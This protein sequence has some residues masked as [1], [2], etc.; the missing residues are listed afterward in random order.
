MSSSVT[1]P[2]RSCQ[3]KRVVPNA[4]FCRLSSDL[5][6]GGCWTVAR[7]AAGRLDLGRSVRKCHRIETGNDR[8]GVRQ[9]RNGQVSQPAVRHDFSD[10]TAGG[11]L[12]CVS[13][14]CSCG[15]C[16]QI[17][18]HTFVPVHTLPC[19]TTTSAYRQ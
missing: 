4:L 14:S 15:R 18:T 1:P 6:A 8:H 2:P 11:I 13:E 17:S 9:I 12:L 19:S 7:F 10:P 16:C 5:P 3:R